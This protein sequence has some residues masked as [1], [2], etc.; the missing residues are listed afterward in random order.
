MATIIKRGDKWRAQVRINGISKS[1]TF[2]TKLEA[3]HWAIKIEGEALAGE[4]EMSAVMT[5]AELMMRY[6]VEVS[7]KKK[8]ARWE[9]FR[10]D[11]ISKMNIGKV[12]L[13][14]FDEVHVYRWREE[15]LTQVSS[16]SVHREWSL[17]SNVCT[18][19]MREWKLLKANPFSIVKKPE[20]AQPRKRVMTDEEVA[21]LVEKLG[22]RE[23]VTLNK[24]MQRVGAALLFALETAMRA[25]EI[26]TLTWDRVHDKYVHLSDTK[27]GYSRD[28]PLSSRARSLLKQLP[29]DKGVCFGVKAAVID[30]T[31]RRVRDI[32]GIDDLHFHDSRRTAL[33]RLAG[34]F[35][36]LTLA[37]ISGHRDVRILLN[38]YY[39]PKIA[40]LAD[41]LD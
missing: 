36:A 5:F 21:L 27:N 28:V 2:P 40:D 13:N 17:L 16:S 31:F 38:T 8:G 10:L 9:R 37:K 30:S 6:S 33:T 41:L 12:T 11:L 24:P 22:Y 18:V 15:R 4:K 14:D 29:K 26:A 39:A 25:S 19:A 32:I 7:P 34:K 23:E 3:Q 35:D 1:G 20:K